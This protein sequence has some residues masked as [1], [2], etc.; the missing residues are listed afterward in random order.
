MLPVIY[1]ALPGLH[2][3][4]EENQEF[5]IQ[6]FLLHK[7]FK[8]ALSF[9]IMNTI[10]L[11]AEEFFNFSKPF[12]YLFIIFSCAFLLCLERVMI[13][14]VADIPCRHSMSC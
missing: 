11:G 10:Y 1:E 13:P 12:I 6:N 3:F 4:F 14:E 7:I 5:A 2:H 8:V 9:R